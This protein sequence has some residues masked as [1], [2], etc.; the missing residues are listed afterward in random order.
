MTRIDLWKR[1]TAIEDKAGSPREQILILYQREGQTKDE[2]WAV[3]E[4]WK[5]GEEVD[6]IDEPYLGG[7]VK[8][9]LALFQ[10]AEGT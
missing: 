1:L 3:V 9:Y 2:M 6:G 8:V 5:Q 10:G 4:R 7:Q